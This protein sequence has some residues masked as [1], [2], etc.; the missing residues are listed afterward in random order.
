MKQNN[1]TN[2]I[3]P[4]NEKPKKGYLNIIIT[5]IITLIIAVVGML[6]YQQMTTK[7]KADTNATEVNVNQDIPVTNEL[8]LE[9]IK[10]NN[11]IFY[12]KVFQDKIED[13]FI[14]NKT[15]IYEL[16]LSTK[17]SK[18]IYSTNESYDNSV[19]NFQAANGVLTFI[20]LKYSNDKN[21]QL[22]QN[23]DIL[24]WNGNEIKSIYHEESGGLPEYDY[25][26]H[27]SGEY[28]LVISLTGFKSNAD[29]IGSDSETTFAFYKISFN[30]PVI[31]K[32]YEE[33]LTTNEYDILVKYNI[34]GWTKESEPRLI[35]EKYFDGQMGSHVDD[36]FAFNPLN[37]SLEKI[38]S[39]LQSLQNPSTRRDHSIMPIDYLF[40]N[41]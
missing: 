1:L 15:E 18:L 4:F 10:N 16:N 26:L 39:N 35:L 6:V 24:L 14:D 30:N 32:V 27:P 29:N 41:N 25:R 11:T 38:I 37:N 19:F 20:N 7:N 17:E 13:N 9:N 3:Q 23:E 12:T 5:S 34:I 31:N 21:N 22:I 2:I 28:V 8:A 33:R 40:Y 36:I